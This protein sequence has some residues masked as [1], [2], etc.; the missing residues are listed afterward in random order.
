MLGQLSTPRLPELG[1]CDVLAP[2]TEVSSNGVT[3]G[4]PSG[5]AVDF[6]TLTYT[7]PDERVFRAAEIPIAKASVAIDPTLGF[8]IVWALAPIDTQL[9]PAA[10]LSVPNGPAWP[11]GTAVEFYVHGIDINEAY[12]P[13]GGW[14][15]ASDGA[16]S[17]DGTRVETSPGGGIPILSAV[18]IR[19]AP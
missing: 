4:V 7:Y 13:Y 5:G 16:V 18:G 2:G 1:S 17:A 11:S 9:C 15:K 10:K 8:E 19:K 3:I 6:D 14:A 12:A